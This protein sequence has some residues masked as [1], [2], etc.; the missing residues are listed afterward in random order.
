MEQELNLDQQGPT[1]SPPGKILSDRS[2]VDVCIE[3]SS[4]LAKRLDY[5]QQ[6][7]LLLQQV[8]YHN[9]SSQQQQPEGAPSRDSSKCSSHVCEV[10]Q[11]DLHS[12]QSAVEKRVSRWVLSRFETVNEDVNHIH[13]SLRAL[14]DNF[15]N[16]EVRMDDAEIQARRFEQRV[17]ADVN[18]MRDPDRRELRNEIRQLISE[19]LDRIDM[20][21]RRR[22]ANVQKVSNKEIEGT[23]LLQS[24]DVKSNHEDCRDHRSEESRQAVPHSSMS[25]H[26]IQHPYKLKCKL[27]GRPTHGE[28]CQI[29]S[30]PLYTEPTGRVVGRSEKPNNDILEFD[31]DFQPKASDW[32]ADEHFCDPT[33]TT[34]VPFS[35]QSQYCSTI[36]SSSQESLSNTSQPFHPTVAN[37]MLSDGWTDVNCSMDLSNTVKTSATP[38]PINHSTPDPIN[39]NIP[40]TANAGVR[41]SHSHPSKSNDGSEIKSSPVPRISNTS[42]ARIAAGRSCPQKSPDILTHTITPLVTARRVAPI[43]DEDG[44]T[45]VISRKSALAAKKKLQNGSVMRSNSLGSRGDGTSEKARR[46]RVILCGR[47]GGNYESCLK[48]L[49]PLKLG[50][51]KDLGCFVDQLG[52]A[53]LEHPERSKVNQCI[54]HSS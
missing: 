6:Q 22:K 47:S 4:T 29:D 49:G 5:L 40:H 15:R 54:N 37:S 36:Q 38:E 20:T 25:S 26:S 19:E 53:L 16:I 28:T 11:D 52:V 1:L 17:I 48:A 33:S 8:A 2:L 30:N 44:F 12:L 27:E 14:A 35:S 10:N 23:Q 3:L 18:E 31:W 50:S 42:W 21:E 43:S 45:T 32:R 7:V 34:D 41:N 46:I 39:Q 9:L 51:R 13:D 24:I